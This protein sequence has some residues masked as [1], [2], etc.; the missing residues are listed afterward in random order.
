MT[1]DVSTIG[2]LN[3]DLL[4][5]GAGP[6]NWE[7]IP[8]WDGPAE[9]KLTA[10]GSVGYTV[11]NMAKLGIDVLVTSCV[12]ADPLGDFIISVLK[13][14]GVNCEMVQQIPDTLTG[15]AAYM[16]LFGN[17]KRPLAYRMPTHQAWPQSFSPEEKDHFLDARLIHNGGYLHFTTVWH[18]FTRDL[19][20]EARAR[21]LMTTM[22]PQF[23]LFAMA[24]PWMTALED[25]LPYIQYLF[26]DEHE[27]HMLT[28]EP[29]LPRAASI[30]LEA[31]PETVIIKQGADGSTVHRKDGK[32][33]QEA[34]RLGELVDSIGAGDTYDAAFILGLLEGWPLE[35]CAL[36]ASIAAGFTVTGVGGTETM[37]T[38]AQVEAELVRRSR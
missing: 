13:S 34:I 28:K 25:V 16:L 35:K 31:G 24:S 5:W 2:P 22:D 11:N 38:R 30:L 3:I 9:M 36:F 26:C 4:I 19:F 14:T 29:D 21:G 1:R 6:P 7:S 37:P 17:R 10:A 33:H 20:K 15:I 27:A 23:P 8:S 32:H 12:P 18:G